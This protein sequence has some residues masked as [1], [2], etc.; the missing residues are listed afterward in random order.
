MGPKVN[1]IP[2]LSMEILR[3]LELKGSDG[4]I[5]LADVFF[6][7][8]GFNKPAIVFNHG[9][10]G[11]KDWGI[12]DTVAKGFAENGF[13]FIKFN[14]SYNGTTPENPM[15]FGDLE[16]FGRNTYSR[17]LYDIQKVFAWVANNPNLP[18][19]LINQNDLNLLGHSRGGA[20]AILAGKQI[21]S[22]KRVATWAAFKDIAERFAS[23]TYSGWQS[24]DVVHIRNGRTG[25][26]MPQYYEIWE[27]FKAHEE[28]YDIR[29]N[30]ATFNKPLLLVHGT[31]DP[32]VI[33]NDALQ[34]KAAYQ[35]ADLYLVPNA[36]HVF[37]GRHPYKEPLLP[38]YAQ[39]A[40]K[41]TVRFFKS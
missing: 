21:R 19:D 33:F 13:V 15:E 17:E 4:K 29:K 5:M 32:T 3:N 6:K 37:G 22:V 26:E 23:N 30:L 27:D 14:Q 7:M 10:K 24:K 36:D 18:T 1:Q 41:E 28:A 12:W 31:E 34:L 39:Q 16:A 8:D 38:V 2:I 40:L 11:F 9:F 35:G 20:T 25:Q